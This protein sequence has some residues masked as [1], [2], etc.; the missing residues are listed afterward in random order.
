MSIRL[1]YSLAPSNRSDNPIS[2]RFL[3]NSPSFELT[4][5]LPGNLLCLEHI[6]VMPSSNSGMPWCQK[7]GQAWHGK[8]DS[9]PWAMPRDW[10]LRPWTVAVGR[11]HDHG[12]ADMAG[13]MSSKNMAMAGSNNA[14]SQLWPATLSHGHGGSGHSRSR[15]WRL[16]SC[17]HD[18]FVASMMGRW[19]REVV[20]KR[21][22]ELILAS[23][24]I[25]C[26]DE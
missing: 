13:S 19:A 26:V 15:P 2:H 21:D 12:A 23:W 1:G 10:E 14:G 22:S 20:A 16:K 4:T 7:S 9:K 8:V 11:D 17:E 25:L 24:A 5:P 18:W 6:R 3:I